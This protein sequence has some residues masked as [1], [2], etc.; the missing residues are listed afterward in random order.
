MR[1]PPVEVQE[2]ANILSCNSLYGFN[3]PLTDGKKKK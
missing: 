1:G 2:R 3:P